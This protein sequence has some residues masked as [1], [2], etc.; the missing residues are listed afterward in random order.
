MKKNGKNIKKRKS[1]ISIVGYPALIVICWLL[2]M[3]INSAMVN[4]R[5]EK[6]G[7]YTWAIIYNKYS[8]GA[9]GTTQTDYF[10]FY[11]GSKYYGY[12]HWDRKKQI[13]D[14]I[15]VFF[16]ES[17]PNINR[18]NSLLKISPVQPDM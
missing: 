3:F 6:K 18:S 8:V 2:Y 15:I 5:L 11:R 10:F 16:L 7:I 12:S 4:Y 14:S 1:I 13:G 17:N 9:K